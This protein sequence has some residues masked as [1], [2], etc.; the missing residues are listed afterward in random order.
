MMASALAALLALSM[1]G[2]MAG[3]MLFIVGSTLVAR[4]LLMP[5]INAATDAGHPTPPQLAGN[6]GPSRGDSAR[7]QGRCRRS[8][9]H[10][11]LR[12]GCEKTHCFFVGGKPPLDQYPTLVWLQPPHT[13]SAL[14]DGC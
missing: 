11:R 3:W 9:A 7:A 4:Q 5:A 8:M 6:T 1:D 13:Q 2:V 10:Q 12:A 14:I